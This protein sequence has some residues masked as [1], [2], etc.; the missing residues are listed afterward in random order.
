MDN[1]NITMNLPPKAS[2]FRSLLKL[3]KF[4]KN[5]IPF[6]SENL[7]E[8]G[9]TYC[10]SL[11][12]GKVGILTIDPDIVQHILLKNSQ[13]Y[14]KP[15]DKRNAL[16]RFVGNGLLV[17]SGDYWARQR[18]LI[19]PG[20]HRKKLMGLVEIMDETIGQ[21]QLELD[22]RILNNK[23]V[24]LAVELKSLTFKNMV[25][26]LFSTSIDDASFNSFFENYSELQRFF[27]NLVRMPILMK[28]YNLNGKTKH[29]TEVS[30]KVKAIITKIIEDRKRSKVEYDDLLG[31]L[32]GLK[33]SDTGEG[34]TSEQLVEE[35]L[36][37]FIAG[38]ETSASI[39]SWIFYLLEQNPSSLAK[40]KQE[41]ELIAAGSKLSFDHLMQM[42]YLNQVI[43]ES[44]RLYPPSWITD[45]LALED[46]HV[47]GFD[48]PKGALLIPFIYGV[49]HNEKYWPNHDQ[50]IPERFTKE[51]KK[52]RHV[53]AHM[54]FGGG[55]RMCI[56]RNFA[57]MQ[58][59]VI[60][61]KML[62][63]YDFTLDPSQK[64]DLLPQVI[65][66]PRYGMKMELNQL[67]M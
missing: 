18:K 14:I 29:Y 7:E 27:S 2:R 65:M 25:N 67:V 57:L 36:I 17:S 61:L 23:V 10:F 66:T 9:D 51:A 59:Q 43:N 37:L 30:N 8:Y 19:S 31:M 63:K 20:F 4:M 44:L 60:V 35:C 24:D 3:Q 54:P 12:Y 15:I 16:S 41:R 39:L 62:E 38:H 11:K 58:M 34:M 55:P 47:A 26:A 49:H 33:Y 64:I 5:P 28:W 6:L 1:S 42:E 46:D 22:K 40:V 52:G 32:M 56:G 21:F 50:F 13:N 53:Y 45:R 48:I